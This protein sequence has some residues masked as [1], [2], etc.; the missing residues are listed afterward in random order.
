MSKY[1]ENDILFYMMSEHWKPRYH[2]IIGLFAL[3]VGGIVVA[4]ISG[5]DTLGLVITIGIG[6]ILII[7]VIRITSSMTKKNDIQRAAF[8]LADKSLPC[9]FH[10]MALKMGYNSM[11]ALQ[12]YESHIPGD[13]PL[14]RHAGGSRHG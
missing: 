3:Y 5:S 4:A 7:Y 11:D 12:C 6:I 9:S 8:D 14:L 13:C 10:I 1:T 2:H